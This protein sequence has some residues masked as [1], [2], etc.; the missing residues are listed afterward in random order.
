MVYSNRQ[1]KIS[2]DYSDAF[3]LH[4]NVRGNIAS[5][6]KCQHCLA[7]KC[8]GDTKLMHIFRLARKISISPP[9]RI[10]FDIKMFK[11]KITS[12]IFLP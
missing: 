6:K 3:L 12:Y 10:L 1:F 4:F 5:C 9:E 11:I 8:V 2:A 7:S